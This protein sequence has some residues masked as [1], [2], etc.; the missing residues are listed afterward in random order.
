MYHDKIIRNGEFKCDKDKLSAS[1][2][3][4]IQDNN[5]KLTEKQNN[6][7]KIDEQESQNDTFFNENEELMI[8]R[9]ALEVSQSAKIA[10]NGCI[11]DLE[12]DSENVGDD[13]VD[14]EDYDDS[15]EE[16]NV[17]IFQNEISNQ[18]IVEEIQYITSNTNQSFLNNINNNSQEPEETLFDANGNLIVSNI[19][20]IRKSHNAFLRVER[21]CGLRNKTINMS[22]NSHEIIERN[23]ANYLIRTLQEIRE[24][25]LANVT[26]SHLLEDGNFIIIL[27]DNKL[28]LGRVIAKYQKIGERHAHINVGVD[29]IDSLSYVSIYLYIHLYG[30][31]FT[32]QSRI[33]GYLFTHIPYKEI[34]YHLSQL[35]YITDEVSD[36]LTIF[37]EAREIFQFFQKE[38]IF[39]RLQCIY[40]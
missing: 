9:A 32:R 7:N 18:I 13:V 15:D 39:Q 26:E 28:C 36:L 10:Q 34:V 5:E 30:G 4:L 20:N 21:I 19:I 16:N 11:G 3:D 27:S 35:D 29:S 17:K 23:A 8:Q 40:K 37:G 33:G 38:E 12:N 24:I 6:E 25:G 1:A 31:M 2:D 14:S 22:D